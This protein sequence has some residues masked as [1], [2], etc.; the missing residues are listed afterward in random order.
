M[1]LDLPAR[2]EGQASILSGSDLKD[3]KEMIGHSDL[4]MTDCYSHLTNMMKHSRQVGL[5]GVYANGSG[6]NESRGGHI[7]QEKGLETK[8]SKL[9]VD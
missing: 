9:D 1:N 2:S 4:K 7:R 8:K 5:V 6:L 3:V